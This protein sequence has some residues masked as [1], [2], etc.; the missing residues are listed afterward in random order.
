MRL[1]V[2]DFTETHLLCSTEHMSER[3]ELGVFLDHS[4]AWGAVRP[5]DERGLMDLERARELLEGVTSFVQGESQIL[6]G[7]HV[8]ESDLVWAALSSLEDANEFV[9]RASPLTWED[10]PRGLDANIAF[11]QRYGEGI[12]PWLD[13]I[14][15]EDGSTP[16]D[17]APNCLLVI[18]G[19]AAANIA[20]RLG[21]KYFRSW[22]ERH[23][24]GEAWVA[25]RA[26]KGEETALAVMKALKRPEKLPAKVKKV[27][28]NAEQ[29]DIPR[30]GVVTRTRLEELL[31]DWELP[32]WDNENNAVCGMVATGFAN[33]EGDDA[34][35]IQTLEHGLGTEQLR[36][37]IYHVR[38]S[39]GPVNIA[40]ICHLAEEDEVADI[41]VGDEIYLPAIKETCVVRVDTT[42]M[43]GKLLKFFKK[44]GQPLD[45]LLI[46]IGQE[47]PH[48]AYLSDDA[49]RQE[50]GLPAT[51]VSLFRFDAFKM[52]EESLDES[53]DFAA[54][55]YALRDRR[56]ITELPLKQHALSGLTY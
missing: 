15:A 44:P 43:K 16:C 13:T 20:L 40:H 56:R 29:L 51:S 5:R 49:L 21:K 48:K 35:V 34:L 31:Q 12:V 1:R 11:V 24:E 37:E 38:R 27:L 25:T 55:L 14:I 10:A 4:M 19:D 45:E 50:L 2:G 28:K 41:N 8:W 32:T 39:D 18:G 7:T 9:A 26:V 33:P 53:D 30:V 54:M 3:E 52:P 23:P 36:R 17:F 46:R 6:N 42:D 22:L 47:F